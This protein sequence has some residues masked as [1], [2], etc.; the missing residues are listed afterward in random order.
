MPDRSIYW[1]KAVLYLHAKQHYLLAL[2]CGG[3]EGGAAKGIA[4]YPVSTKKG[5]K[6]DIQL[7]GENPHNM[8]FH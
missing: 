2:V 5:E 3:V 8:P 4:H 6:R 1:G 7:T